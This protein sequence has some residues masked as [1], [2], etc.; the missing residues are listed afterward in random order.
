MY[1]KFEF[2]INSDS[3]TVK[4]YWSQPSVYLL[5]IGVDENYSGQGVKIRELRKGGSAKKAR[6]KRKDILLAYDGTKINSLADIDKFMANYRS[7]NPGSPVEI[8]FKR[9][10]KILAIS[11]YNYFIIIW[12]INYS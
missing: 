6:L 9:K 7:N 2:E 1:E 4:S 12:R 10:K 5:G 11:N 8:T 3:K